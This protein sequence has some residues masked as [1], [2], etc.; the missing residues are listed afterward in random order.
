L[1][2]IGILRDYTPE[3]ICCNI[4]PFS[5]VKPNN[6]LIYK[7]LSNLK[8]STYLTGFIEA[9]GTILVPKTERSIKGKINYPSI[10][11]M[12]HLKNLPLALMIQKE[13]KNGSISRKKG[14]NAYILTINSFEGL[15]L[16]T[17]IINGNMRTPKIHALS[18]LID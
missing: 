4:I 17:S 7:D 5:Q 14:V 9:E 2:L 3:L 15:L 8:F 18:N 6:I 1:S 16:I 12:F 11:I 10:Q 13:L